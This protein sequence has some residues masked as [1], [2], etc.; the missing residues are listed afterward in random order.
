MNFPTTTSFPSPAQDYVEEKLD[1]N[2][3]LIKH[4]AATFFLRVEGD[5]MTGA[6]IFPGDILVVDRAIEPSDGKVVIAAIN[7]DLIV[8]RLS[9]KDGKFALLHENP[10]YA[11]IEVADGNQILRRV[12]LRAISYWGNDEPRLLELGFVPKS[13]IWIKGKKPKEAPE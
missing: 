12:F 9:E 13:E 1:L 6:G 4:P 3:R 10:N 7:G 2:K 5:A 11:P 8:R